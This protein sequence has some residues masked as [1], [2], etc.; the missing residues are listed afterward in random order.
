MDSYEQLVNDMYRTQ[1]SAASVMVCPKCKEYS[2]R[3]EHLIDAKVDLELF[4]LG[5]NFNPNS[6][7]DI[8]KTLRRVAKGVH[9][10]WIKAIDEKRVPS[11]DVS[12]GEGFEYAADLIEK[13]IRRQKD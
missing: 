8:I 5:W 3:L 9:E 10:Q 6:V 13:A 4:R 2:D 12:P 11:E 1:C 7:E